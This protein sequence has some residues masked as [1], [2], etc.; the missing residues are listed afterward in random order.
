MV[1]KRDTCRVAGQ[2]QEDGRRLCLC[3]WHYDHPKAHPW[4]LLMCGNRGNCGGIRTGDEGG[5]GEP[6]I[7]LKR[8][9]QES[10]A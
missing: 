4:T 7:I 1:K 3:A 5:V 9:V 6:H 10:A 8:K 2:I